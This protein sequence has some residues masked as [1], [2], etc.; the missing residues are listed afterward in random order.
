MLEHR[1]ARLVN[2]VADR[3]M[4]LF[5]SF[6]AGPNV[7]RPRPI[8]NF[9]AGRSGQSPQATT[10]GFLQAWREERRQAVRTWIDG[11]FV[12]QS[13]AMAGGVAA[14]QVVREAIAPIFAK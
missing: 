12:R 11:T 13:A 8:I 3:V 6:S 2:G 4:G 1:R 9:F 7:Q 5:A 14:G 10:L